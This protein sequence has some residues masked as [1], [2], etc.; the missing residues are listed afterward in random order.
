MCPDRVEKE[1]EQ[2]KTRKEQQP[3]N[4]RDVGIHLFPV[5]PAHP[6]HIVGQN[7]PAMKHVDHHPLV[8]FPEH[9][10]GPARLKERKEQI[11]KCNKSKYV[12]I[13]CIITMFF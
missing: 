11:L 9:G 13:H 10:L 2:S 6:P 3:L 12:L 7:H 4:Q 8:S 1:G 5:I